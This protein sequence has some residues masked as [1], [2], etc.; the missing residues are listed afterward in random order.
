MHIL[1]FVKSKNLQSFSV[2]PINK[3]CSVQKRGRRWGEGERGGFLIRELL[4]KESTLL[5]LDVG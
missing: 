1:E 4:G 3:S 5:A 2:L